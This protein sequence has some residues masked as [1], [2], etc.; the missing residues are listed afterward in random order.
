MVTTRKIKIPTINT[1][2][3]I[4]TIDK[5]NIIVEKYAEVRNIP[6]VYNTYFRVDDSDFRLVTLKRINFVRE[7]YHNEMDRTYENSPFTADKT[8]HEI[9]QL[10]M[11]DN[12]HYY[13]QID[14]FI[15][16]FLYGMPDV[17]KV[18]DFVELNELFHLIKT[19]GKNEK[20]YDNETKR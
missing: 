12:Y 3:V 8:M 16:K 10:Y 5:I 2:K 15:T 17:L 4:D 14:N 13:I 18:E 19:N 6:W 1:K 9:I 20:M 7:F 11:K